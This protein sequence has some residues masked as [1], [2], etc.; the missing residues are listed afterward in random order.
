MNDDK[1]VPK[2][3]PADAELTE[4]NA[5]PPDRQ[6][7]LHLQGIQPDGPPRAVRKATAGLNLAAGVSIVLV[8]G[9][10]T[11]FVVGGSVHTCRGATRSSQLQWQQQQTEI[12]EALA[13]EQTDAAAQNE[14]RG[15][16]ADEDVRR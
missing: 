5:G 11:M 1:S 16:G 2:D 13:A 3:V 14:R 12:Q 9:A 15:S 4:P 7:D 6:D 8:A 10:S